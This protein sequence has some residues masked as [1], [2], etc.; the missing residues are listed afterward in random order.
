MFELTVSWMQPFSSYTDESI[1]LG[2]VHEPDEVVLADT[3]GHWLSCIFLNG[4]MLWPISKYLPT[5][6]PNTL[7]RRG[8]IRDLSVLNSQSG[9]S[10]VIDLG[11]NLED[12]R[13]EACLL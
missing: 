11:S 4:S 2:T 12:L 6:L 9:H 13:G 8:I 10:S 1:V 5:Y 7:K 3:I